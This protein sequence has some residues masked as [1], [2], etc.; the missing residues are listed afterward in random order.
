MSEQ[1][2]VSIVVPTHNR[3]KYAIPCVKSLL[4]IKS[5]RLQVV[6]HDTSNDDC[7]LAAWAADQADSRLVYVHW[8]SRL[9]MTENHERAMQLAEG[10][11]V[12]LIGDDD[13]VSQRILEAAEYAKA[14]NVDMLTPRVKAFY[15]WPDFRTKF[16]GAAHAGRIYLETFGRGAETLQASKQL[17]K[18]LHEACQ[19][20]DA[21][22][23]LYHGLV[24]RS[25]LDELRRRSGK[26]FFGT[27]PDMSASVSLAMIGKTYCLLDF[28]FTMP[29]GGGG[30]NSGRSAMGKHKG[31]LKDDPHMK[32][33]TDLQWPAELPMFFSVETVWAHAA[34][35]TL[36]G[37]KD[38]KRQSQF[39]LARLYAL[40]LFYH[41]DYA[42]EIFAAR[43]AAQAGGNGQVGM[44][45]LVSEFVSVLTKY[46]FSR[47]KRVMKPN[48]SNG[49]EVVGV[50]EDVYLARQALDS[51]LEARLAG[52][53][54]CTSST[55]TRSVTE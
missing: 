28:P 33:F 51:K 23:K 40:C 26:I 52:A 10:E 21:L 1:Y 19:G 50:V 29:G 4:E 54:I 39:N 5:E 7:Q 53:G 42:K 55:R 46:T 16:Y 30:S 44:V 32:P 8:K 27:S 3:S 38:E 14:E 11:Y 45:R 35:A 13:T 25:L 49:R 37:M 9:S 20:T 31:N 47:L 15:Y 48:A 43:R 12:C 36:E 24:R 2:L 6:V 18:A 22:P 17:D 41:R 34:W